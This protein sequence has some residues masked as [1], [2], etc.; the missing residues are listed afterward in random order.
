MMNLKLHYR[1]IMY[2]MEFRCVVNKN[3]INENKFMFS[4]IFEYEN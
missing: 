1:V 4:N 3:L 2:D